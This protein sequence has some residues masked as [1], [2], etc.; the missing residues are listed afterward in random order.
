MHQAEHPALCAF[1]D[2][3]LVAFP[4]LKNNIPPALL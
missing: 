2:L 3:D 1:P 4:R